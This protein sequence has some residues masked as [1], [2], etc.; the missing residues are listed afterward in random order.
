MTNEMPKEADPCE[1]TQLRARVKELESNECAWW[2][3]E[4]S[5]TCDNLKQE[6]RIRELEEA[7]PTSDR[8]GIMA[9]QFAYFGDMKT[10]GECIK[11]AEKIDKVIKK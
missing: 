6:A 11:M 9:G 1:L 5:I 8:I 10:A 4:V 2:I 3:K 7:M